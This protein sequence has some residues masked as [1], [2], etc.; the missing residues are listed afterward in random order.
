MKNWRGLFNGMI[1]TRSKWIWLWDDMMGVAV[2]VEVPNYPWK[3]IDPD[4]THWM[5]A[6]SNP[7]EEFP[8]PPHDATTIATG[9]DAITAGKGITFSSGTSTFE[10]TNMMKDMLKELREKGL[11]D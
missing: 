5:A 6:T 2:N 7:K 10:I 9:T 8:A 4:F 11:V 3:K 1:Q